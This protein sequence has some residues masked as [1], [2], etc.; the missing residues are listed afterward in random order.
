MNETLL[1]LA[2]RAEEKCAGRFAEIDRVAQVNTEKVLA[3]FAEERVQTGDF[4]GTTGYGYDD[5]GRDKL[6]R[7][8][9]RVF[10]A[11]KALVRTAFVNGTHAIACAMFACLSPGQT[12][13]S[14]TGG[15][16]DTLETVAGL[17]GKVP[18][19]F[20]DYGMGFRQ[21]PLKHGA[22]DLPAILEAVRAPDVAAVFIQRSRGYGIRK[23]LSPEEIGALCREIRVLRPEMVI[24]VD[25]SYG[26]FVCEAEPV[27]MGADLMAASLI[28][29]PGGGLA[30]CGGYIAGRADLVER[31]AARM[32]LPGIGGECGATLGV[33]RLLYQGFFLAPHVTAQAVKTG[34]FCAA[35][36]EELGYAVSPTASEPRYDI[37]QTI[38]FGAP[39]VLIRFCEGIQSASPVDS[40]AAPVPGDMPGYEDPVIMAAGAFIQGSSIE[41]SCDAPMRPPFTCYLQGG[42]TYEAGKLGI[43][44]AAERMMRK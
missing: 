37:I 13:V 6:E 15:V 16:Y 2:R 35:V 40:F 5:V 26:E 25:N 8:Y 7:I 1:A 34:A 4:A 24:L 19:S 18:G 39:D 43:L 33:N 9:A 23:T 10:G 36:M 38:D 31:A 14:V 20:A 11:E 27:A 30:P 17:R 29:N 21:V 44:R 42:L 41:L 28:K 32:T 3:A 22:P 12:M